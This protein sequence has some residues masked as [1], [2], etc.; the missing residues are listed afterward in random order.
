[1]ADP[2]AGVPATS[3]E[4]ELRAEKLRAEL[5]NHSWR[6]YALDAPEISDAAYD[7]LLRVLEAI[8]TAYPELITSDSPTQR[9]GAA[10]SDAFASVTHAQRMYSLENAMNMGELDAWLGRIEREMVGREIGFMCELKIDG[11]SLALTY[12]NGAL[13]RGATRGDGVTGEDVTANVRTIKSVPLRLAA[14]RPAAV[15]E[16]LAGGEDSAWRLEVR[17]EVYMPKASFARLNEEQD[18]AGLSAFSNPRNAAA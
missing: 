14:Q 9:I 8:E 12:E 2:Q 4:A 10:P 5:R 3:D 18:E 1:M 7:A 17:G 13:V 15:R 11:S 16:V 6:Y